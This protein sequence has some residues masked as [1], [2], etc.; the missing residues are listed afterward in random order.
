M[1]LRIL[2]TALA[3]AAASILWMAAATASA[4]N[5]EAPEGTIYTGPVAAEAE[6]HVVLDNPI[7]KIECASTVEGEIESHGEGVPA[8]GNLSTLTFTGC[9]DSWHVTVVTA[10]SLSIEHTSGSDGDLFSTGATV[11]ATRFGITCRYATNNTTVGTVT[12]GAPATLDISASIPFHSGSVFCGSGGTAWTGSYEVTNLAEL[13]VKQGV[14]VPS[15]VIVSPHEFEAGKAA[16]VVKIEDNLGTALPYEL[17]SASVINTG[18]TWT[19]EKEVNCENK[20]VKAKGFI[21]QV[22]VKC[23]PGK[24]KGDIAAE[25]KFGAP[26]KVLRIRTPVICK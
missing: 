6:G 18:G 11:E 4:T 16:I 7:A 14:K 2:F 24:G 9:T 23:G 12:G 13:Q 8:K 17:L 26:A 1:N 15:T 19:L 22:E 25:M 5:I 10:G 20:E 21:C 3:M